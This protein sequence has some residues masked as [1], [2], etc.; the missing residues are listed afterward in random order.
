[1]TAAPPP[2]AREIEA[3]TRE[4]PEEI[5]AA[6]LA[7]SRDHPDLLREIARLQADFEAEFDNAFM[8][9]RRDAARGLHARYGGALHQLMEDSGVLRYTSPALEAVLDRD[10]LDLVE[11]RL[12]ADPGPAPELDLVPAVR[13]AP[14]VDP[15][16]RVRGVEGPRAV[17]ASIM[18][19]LV[20]GNT[21][22]PSIMIGER[23]ADFVKAATA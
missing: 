16:L 4:H 22:A 5:R 9:V 11:V 23:C 1:M 19:R 2:T 13:L 6:A 3:L 20:S 14:M 12:G 21:N 10:T 7:A 15:A 8:F 17:D 18:P